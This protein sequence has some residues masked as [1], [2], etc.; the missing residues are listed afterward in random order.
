MSEQLLGHRQE[1]FRVELLTTTDTVLRTLAGVQ[2]D[3]G[4]LDLS[5]A[6][7][8]RSSGNLAT[9]RIGDDVDWLQHRVR[10]SYVLGDDLVEPLITAIGAAPVEG[11]TATGV[12]VDV[13]LYDKTLILKDD[14][15]LGHYGL[16]EGTPI[17]DAIQD[18]IA[19]T[20]EAGELVGES[21]AV[22]AAPMVWDP[23]TT[24]LRI[25]NDLADAAG[26]FALYCDG[27]GRYRADTYVPPAAR[28]IA[29]TFADDTHGLYLP[30]WTRD[31]DVS[32][33][34]NRYV[35]VGRSTGDTAALVSVATDEDPDS[36]FSFQARGRWITRTDT[37][38]EAAS[39]GILDL[40]AVRRLAEAQ[41]VGETITITHPWLPIRLNDVVLFRHARTGESRGVLQRQTVNLTPGG[42]VQSTIRRIR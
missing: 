25:C 5:V 40:I 20:G 27:W 29:W 33:V 15:F 12:S 11:H 4:Q 22:L 24:K 26:C 36:P 3:A 8:I 23:G 39:Q 37:D 38:V 19:S 18:V 21:D 14:S 34:P 35:C 2:A 17:L 30:E 41:M 10:V 1:S 28:G 42:L 7:T 31:L 9:E 6:A 32:G 16:P 13:E